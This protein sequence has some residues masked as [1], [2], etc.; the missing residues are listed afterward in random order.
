MASTSMHTSKIQEVEQASTLCE[1]LHCIPKF[2]LISVHD[3]Y[4]PSFLL[5]NGYF[6]RGKRMQMRCGAGAVFLYGKRKF[7]TIS[8]TD[9][10][11][12]GISGESEDN[13]C[14]LF[15][16]AFIREID[17]IASKRKNLQRE[18]DRR[19][20][21]QLLIC[22]DEPHRATNDGNK[23]SK[24]AFYPGIIML[25]SILKMVNHLDSISLM[26]LLLEGDILFLHTSKDLIRAFIPWLRQEHDRFS[27]RRDVFSEGD[28]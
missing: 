5:T 19:I 4:V 1:L 11:Y 20:V 10:Y 7:A 9:T 8:V 16:K 18:T 6:T 13:I 23:K 28:L 15:T 14:E 22:I 24:Q 21:A 17:A 25:H 2:V 3:Y 27:R 26:K 12:R